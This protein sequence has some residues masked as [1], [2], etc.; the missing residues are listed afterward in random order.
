MTSEA[1]PLHVTRR[2]MLIGLAMTG[3]A[4]AFGGIALA[5]P[6]APAAHARDWEWLTGSWDVWHRRLKKRLAGNNEWEE[7]AGKSSFWHTLGGLGNVDDNLLNFPSGEY[8]GLSVRAFDPATNKWSIWWLDGRSAT[9]LDPPVVGGFEG[10]EGVFVGPDTFNDRPVTVRFRWHEV[11]SKR[12]HW[13]QALSTDGG[14]NWEINWRNYFTR[15][16]ATPT[17]L[18]R[19]APAQREQDDWSF[20]VGRWKVHNRRRADGA[21]WQEFDSTLHNW[22]VLGGLG[23]VGDNVFEAPAGSYRGVSV[24][25][26]DITT[27]QWQSW[28]LDGRTPARIAPSVRGGFTNGIGTLIGDDERE[29]RPVKVRSRW[30]EIT[31]DSAHWEQALSTDGGE[32]WEPNWVADFKRVVPGRESR[33]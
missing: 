33:S 31:P 7:F 5:S 15:T 28:W 27:R 29:G 2:N 23:N 13:D 30:S 4:S 16:S 22:P 3:G 1:P 12:P 8:R 10:D 18:P 6:A 21:G 26:F 11:H 25:A 14:A 9:K 32:R 19:S 20:L 17:L 24:R